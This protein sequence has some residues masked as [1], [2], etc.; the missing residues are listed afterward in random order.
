MGSGLT[1]GQ[2]KWEPWCGHTI[3][4]ADE[5]WNVALNIVHDAKFVA[6]NSG[7]DW[8]IERAEKAYDY[9][10]AVYDRDDME[11]VSTAM[12]MA[13]QQIIDNDVIDEFGLM[14]TQAQNDAGLDP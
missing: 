3:N 12:K 5:L 6:N 8:L 11:E 13:W 10:D 7:L 14:L 9:V 4:T 2:I 1:Y